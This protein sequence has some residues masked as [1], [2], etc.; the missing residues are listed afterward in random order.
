MSDPLNEDEAELL[1]GTYFADIIADRWC[2]CPIAK[3]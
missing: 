3:A 1:K 2:F